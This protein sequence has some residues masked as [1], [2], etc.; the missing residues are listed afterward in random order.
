VLEE[1]YCLDLM[2]AKFREAIARE[3]S[4]CGRWSAE[5]KHVQSG[6]RNPFTCEIPFDNWICSR[7]EREAAEL[8][9][10][11][12]RWQKRQRAA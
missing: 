6:S 3:C 11:L 12:N 7:C 9:E 2:K 10:A 8:R 4:V 1:P 5:G